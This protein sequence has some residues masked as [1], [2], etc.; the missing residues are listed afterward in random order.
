M[1]TR[2]IPPPRDGIYRPRYHP[3]CRPGALQQNTPKANPFKS[4]CNGGEPAWLSPRRWVSAGA[5]RVIFSECR[6]RL[7]PNPGS[8]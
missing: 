2:K 8:L 4:L 1:W 7:P 6:T 5:S 3:I